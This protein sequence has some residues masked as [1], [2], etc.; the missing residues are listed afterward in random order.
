MPPFPLYAALC[1]HM[2]KRASLF[3]LGIIS[4]I[5]SSDV[6]EDDDRAE[7]PDIVVGGSIDGEATDGDVV[8]DGG[9]CCCRFSEGEDSDDVG[10]AAIIADGDSTAGSVVRTSSESLVG[11]VVLILLFLLLLL[12]LLLLFLLLLL[13]VA[14]SG[15]ISSSSVASR[16]KNAATDDGDDELEELPVP[17]RL[18]CECDDGEETSCDDS[19]CSVI[20]IQL[21]DLSSSYNIIHR[22][23]Q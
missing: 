15:E 19:C 8:V 16:G 5:R 23:V 20:L 7:G 13:P 2:A 18:G 9:R 6:V 1:P 11:I 10:G 17:C 14:L 22:R 12:L 4:F 3:F 21:L